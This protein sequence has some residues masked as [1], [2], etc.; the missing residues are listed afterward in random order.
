MS[1]TFFN[2]TIDT[3]FAYNDQNIDY[4]G[5]P[6]FFLILRWWNSQQA[7][8]FTNFCMGRVATR[9]LDTLCTISLAIPSILIKWA[10]SPSILSTGM[11]TC[12]LSALSLQ[13]RSLLTS[14]FDFGK[15][16]R[17]D[18][19]LQLLFD[20]FQRQPLFSLLGIRA[21]VSTGPDFT[22][23]LEL[24]V[25]WPNSRVKFFA[26]QYAKLSGWPFEPSN[27]SVRLVLGNLTLFFWPATEH[28]SG[29]PGIIF[30]HASTMTSCPSDTHRNAWFCFRPDDQNVYPFK[31]RFADRK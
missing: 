5:D 12:S 2:G 27:V 15:G 23:F 26:E 11:K 28:F 16:S 25:P 30:Y 14:L 31:W 13:P 9:Q 7:C 17:S 6:S 20:R 22:I 21:T 18:V 29:G 19:L 24:Q 1:T 8:P 10:A 4:S 3:I